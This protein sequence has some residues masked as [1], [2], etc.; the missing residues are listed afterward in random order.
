MSNREITDPKQVTGEK[1]STEIEKSWPEQ[2]YTKF[3]K[4]GS[5]V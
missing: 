3:L 1:D 2:L 5:M 4:G